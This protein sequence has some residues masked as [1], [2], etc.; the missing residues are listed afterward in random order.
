MR[1]RVWGYTAAIAAVVVMGLPS[2]ASAFDA[3]LKRYPYL[4]DLVGTSVMVNW[5]TDITATSAVVKYGLNGGTCDTNTVTAT[6]TFILVNGVSEYQWKAQLTGLT[7]DTEYCYRVYFGSAQLDLLA[8]DAS[9]VFRSQVPAGSSTPFKFA[10]W[11]NWGK[12]LAA[13]NP[14]Q[15]NVISQIAQS[16]ARFAV[17][18]GDNAYEVGSQ[19]SYGDL[20]QVG[21]NTSAVF[22]PNYW[23]VAGASVP[24]FPAIG[25][26]DHN[27]DVL[28]TNFP[29]DT[30]VATSGGQYTTQTYCCTNGTNQATYPNGW[31]AFDAGLAR[32]YVLET[33]WE[34]T[35]VGTADLFKNDFDNHWGPSSPQYQWLKNDLETHPRALRFAFHHFPMYS[36]Q[37]ATSSDTF[38][39]GAG[40]E[41]LLK[42]HDVTVDF[43][44]HSHNYQ[45]NSV[46]AG[47][48]LTYVSGGGGANLESIGNHSAGCS[49]T[50]LYGL[51]W[52]NV[53]NS[54]Y[55][56]GAAP[57]PTGK[58]QVH[59]FLLVSVSGTS[60]TVTPT[61][62]LG[63]TFDPV[64]YNAPAQ[65]A[66]ISVTKSDSPDPVLVGQQVTY[67]L[68]V[69]NAGPRAATG[70]LV[71]D[72]LPAGMTFESA[73]PSQGTCSQSGVTV[74]C[75]LGTVANGANATIQIKGRPQ[76][77]GTIS[78]TATVA[79]N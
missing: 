78:N 30:A 71:T 76:S 21:D 15:A 74:S 43:S 22:G 66:N 52:S 54:G 49:A 17:T 12:T 55:A 7:P 37:S 79:S 61:N 72:T 59:H 29:Q 67:T 40:L 42:L 18:A 75:Q 48:V 9:P 65:N 62:S 8:P 73:T 31:Y 10:V 13:G 64:T 19:K 26:H 47:G 70:T 53:N 28:L 58:E 56:C 20:Y 5:A 63:G 2:G 46:P 50:N 3:K 45:R 35:N 25:N 41:G 32:F 6:R 51:G 34:D 33:A 14:H 1:G 4:T 38:L 27:N 23:K 44:A 57:V 16:G 69:S 60:V 36:D 77:T 24:I 11:G 39:Q 68:T